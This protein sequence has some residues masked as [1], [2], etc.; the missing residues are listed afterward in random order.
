MVLDQYKLAR[1]NS[2][3]RAKV[4]AGVQLVSLR[5]KVSRILDEAGRLAE[6]EIDVPDDR[7]TAW[8]EDVNT[9]VASMIS[10]GAGIEAFQVADELAAISEAEAPSE[11][12]PEDEIPSV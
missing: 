6:Y 1:L 3:L 4:N 11:A 5:E 8:L 10:E 7:I 9:S 2:S 12:E